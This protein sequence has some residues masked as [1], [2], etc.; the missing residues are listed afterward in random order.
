M[1]SFGQWTKIDIAC[2]V[3]REERRLAWRRY[4]TSAIM[5]L[6]NIYAQSGN[7]FWR[8][9]IDL[10]EEL[11]LDDLRIKNLNRLQQILRLEG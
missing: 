9:I 3:D 6:V 1:S 7:S 11:G 10:R 5:F 4:R 2:L 8:Q